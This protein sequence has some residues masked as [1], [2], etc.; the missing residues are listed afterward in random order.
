MVSRVELNIGMFDVRQIADNLNLSPDG[1]WV[2][3]KSTDFAFLP[4]DETDWVQ[5]QQHSFWYQ[6]RNNCFKE[7]F[8]NFSPSGVLLEV[9]AGDGFVSLGL[10]QSGIQVVAI[11][12]DLKHARNAKRRGVE[13][14]IS[15]K[16]EDVEWKPGCVSG[17][18]LF[19][20]LEHV[21]DEIDFLRQI[22]HQLLK[23][24]GRL[25]ISVPAYKWLWS[26]EDDEACHLRRYSMEMLRNRLKAAGFMI[27]YATYFFS[28]LVVPI[29]FF[30]ALPTRFGIR[31]DRT[32]LSSYRE[33][34]LKNSCGY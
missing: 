31:P 17:V 23:P 16:I 26:K 27:E 10:Q 21:E 25:Y 7:L 9:E 8:K 6:H 30:R 4:D 29:F 33:H 34:N 5:V 13:N 18:G 11:E 24:S 14:V 3:P 15:A 22:R 32:H 19:D 12:P 28:V 20:V 1:I 2:A